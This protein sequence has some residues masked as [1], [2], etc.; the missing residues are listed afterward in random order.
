MAKAESKDVIMKVLSVSRMLG[1]VAMLI[2]GLS[3]LMNGNVVAGGLLVG[4]TCLALAAWALQ[5]KRE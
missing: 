4:L 3:A 2:I 5:R 1:A